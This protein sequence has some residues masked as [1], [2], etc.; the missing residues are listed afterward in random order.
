MP[1]ESPPAAT[2]ADES[3]P[4]TAPGGRGSLVSALVTGGLRVV[5]DLADT[6]RERLETPSSTAAGR[7]VGDHG[8]NEP[9]ASFAGPLAKQVKFVLIERSLQPQKQSIIAQARRVHRFLIDEQR[10]NNAAH[11]HQMLPLTAV[12]GKARNLTRTDRAD[13]PQADLRHHALKPSARDT[14]PR[15]TAEIFIDDLHLAPA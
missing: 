10:V 5:T 1:P 6:V 14:A 13:F 7:P 2:T 9:D 12:T 8:A 11:L 4:P 15:R 3:T